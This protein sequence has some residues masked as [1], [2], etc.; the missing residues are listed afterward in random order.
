MRLGVYVDVSFRRDGDRLSGDRAFV[1]FL[2][3]LA[4]HL[5]ELVFLG[6]LDPSRGL[7]P[8]P[9]VLPAE[10]IRLAPL[11]YYRST[12]SAVD[13]LRSVRGS[14]VA[15]KRELPRL[16]ALWLFGPHPLALVFSRIA[17]R[18]GTPIY[19][20]IRQELVPYAAARTSGIRRAWAL[21]VAAGLELAFRRLARRLPTVV[22][23]APLARRYAGGRAP[24]LTAAFSLVRERDLVSVDVALARPWTGHLQL[25]S[26]GR[27]SP[28]KN[29]LLLADILAQL[30]GLEPRWRLRVVGD[31]PLSSRLAARAARLGVAERLELAGYVPSG[32]ALWAEYGS[33]HAFLHVSV[34]EGLPQVLLEAHAAG[35]PVVATDVGGV[36]EALGD[37]SSGIL[38]PPRDVR[39]AAAAVRRLQ[40]EPELRRELVTAGARAVQEHTLEKQCARILEFFRAELR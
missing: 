5:D 19:L 2:A 3:G 7:G 14:V 17:R 35:I 11:P 20:G 28:E 22:V 15:L 40:N 34:T 4:P 33:S 36:R 37:G 8:Y 29:P 39:A 38:V 25:L 9:H 13:L 18:R 16:D 1:Q 6:R 26:V 12:A 32:P 24:T 21:P 31:G 10:R 23:S 27:L 30:V